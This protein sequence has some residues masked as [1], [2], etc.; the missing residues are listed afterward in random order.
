M[1]TP[2]LVPTSAVGVALAAAALLGQPSPAAAQSVERTMFVSALDA[3]GAPVEQ[4]APS[5]VMVREDGV[6]R[7]V[8]RVRRATTPMQIAVLVDNSAATSPDITNLREAILSFV[9]AMAPG[10]EIS[11]VAYADRPTILTDPTSN[12]VLL[13]QG[14][15]R[16]FAQPNAGGYVLDAILETCR[17]FVKREAARP[18]IVVFAT[19]TVEFSHAHADQVIDEL[20]AAGA[21]LHALLLTRGGGGDLSN[22]ELR[23]RAVVFDRGTR[24]T[25]GQRVDLL[26]SMGFTAVAQ[27]LAAELSGQFEV[28]FARP[29]SLIPP[30]TTTVESA[31]PGLTVRGMLARAPSRAPGA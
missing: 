4:L 27:T 31:S 29:A 13:E 2:R 11:L 8:L 10:N 26:S 9:K 20:E 28:V 1:I 23:N 30:S 5:D 18:V 21:A 22:T 19:E 15:G 17:G 14:V 12:L 24:E 3:R 16:I 6:A 25:G 7:E